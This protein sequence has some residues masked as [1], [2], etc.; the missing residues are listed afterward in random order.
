MAMRLA[1]LHNVSLFPPLGLA[2]SI[3]R[4]A[5]VLLTW[6]MHQQPAVMVQALEAAA[7]SMLCSAW[8]GGLVTTMGSTMR[9]VGATLHGTLTALA[10]QPVLGTASCAVPPAWCML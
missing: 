1:G 2:C 10:V 8:L 5:A 9:L 6:H 3:D 4:Q 7:F